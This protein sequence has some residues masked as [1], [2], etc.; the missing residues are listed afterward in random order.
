[1][2]QCTIVGLMCQLDATI[3]LPFTANANM[4][5]F[6]LVIFRFVHPSIQSSFVLLRSTRVTTVGF[7]RAPSIAVRHMHKFPWKPFL[8]NISFR[9][10]CLGKLNNQRYARFY[11]VPYDRR[12]PTKPKRKWFRLC[13]SIVC[14]KTTS[15]ETTTTTNSGVHCRFWTRKWVIKLNSFST[16]PVSKQN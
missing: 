10:L 7:E 13:I 16:H 14:A 12:S 2:Q 5:F 4:N 15:T 9:S 8:A 6:F 11:C 3:F 1:M